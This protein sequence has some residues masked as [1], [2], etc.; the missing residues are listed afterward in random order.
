MIPVFFRSDQVR[1][2][3]NNNQSLI[4]CNIEKYRD[5]ELLDPVSSAQ[6]S[7]CLHLCCIKCSHGWG[8]SLIN[9]TPLR[10]AVN[11]G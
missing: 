4:I 5:V 3:V 7:D 9:I 8:S 2:Y 10:T 1:S 11:T 6:K